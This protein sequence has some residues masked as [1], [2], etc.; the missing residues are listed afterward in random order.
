MDAYECIVPLRHGC[1]LNSHPAPS[2]LVRLV[3][4]EERE[5]RESVEDDERSE[6]P[7]TSRTAENIEKVSSAVSFCS[8]IS[9]DNLGHMS[10]DTH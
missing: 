9:W 1:T 8:K 10:V 3:K 7:Q 2:P 5:G 6:R 4:G